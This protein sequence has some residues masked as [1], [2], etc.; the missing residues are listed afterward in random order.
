MRYI[1]SKQKLLEHIKKV[2]EKL[3]VNIETILD[4]FSGTATVAKFLNDNGYTVSTCDMQYYSYILQYCKVKV[5]NKN[6]TFK[7]LLGFENKE[8]V[9]EYFNNYP[10]EDLIEGFIYNNYCPTGTKYS[11]FI[12]L[13]FSDLNGKLIDTFRTKIQ[14]W[15]DMKQINE[16]EYMWLLG[17]LLEGISLVSN[18]A[19]VYGA[20]LKKLQTNA[21]KR[22]IMKNHFDCNG[23]KNNKCYIMDAL[24]CI[25]QNEHTV[26]Y[27]DPPYNT[28]QYCDNYHILETIA[29]Y[30]NPKIF[31]KTGKRDTTSQKS[32]FSSKRLVKK[33]WDNFFKYCKSKY[34][35]WSYSSDSLLSK[36][37]IID[38][39]N[40]YGKLISFDEINHKKF[41][42]NKKTENNGVIEYLILTEKNNNITE[43]VKDVTVEEK[44]CNHIFKCGRN[45]CNKLNCKKHKKKIIKKI[46]KKK[47]VKKQPMCYKTIFNNILKQLKVSYNIK[48]I[49][50][51]NQIEKINYNNEA[52]KYIIYIW[53]KIYK[54][55]NHNIFKYILIPIGLNIE[56]DL[57]SLN[58]KYEN[59][60]DFYQEIKYGKMNKNK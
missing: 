46:I 42:S 25:K 20:Y 4:G 2:I 33:E 10:E 21:K 30:D 52:M 45:K 24:E 5:N 29:L 27:F 14:S 1:G 47:I 53:D 35:L 49:N 15:F 7:K 17:N 59:I 37:E 48:N 55:D 16:E 11:K 32:K 50:G 8:E 36:E 38:I 31:G 18:I 19:G 34:L 6:L 41:V 39:C 54:Q 57:K 3:G 44:L 43:E 23:N 26:C 13:Y 51:D 9:L 22:L 60:L 40:K 58:L 28:R 12:R 56:K